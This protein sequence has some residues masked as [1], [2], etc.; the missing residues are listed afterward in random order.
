MDR[1]QDDD[2]GEPLEALRLGKGFSSGERDRILEQLDR[3]NSRLRSLRGIDME[4]SVKE[5]DGADQRVTLELWA[6]GIP[7]LV[8]TS[9]KDELDAALHEVRDDLARQVND[10]VTR[11][12][13]HHNR[14]ARR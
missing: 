9:S 1:Q 6:S 8:A 10:T 7:R 3:L 12:E 13:R 4:L 5:R 2:E 14:P 11:G